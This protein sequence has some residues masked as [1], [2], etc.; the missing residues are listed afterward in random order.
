MVALANPKQTDRENSQETNAGRGREPVRLAATSRRHWKWGLLAAALVGAGGMA[1]AWAGL[2]LEDTRPVAVL[3]SDLP[4]GHVLTAA[5]VRTADVPEAEGLRMLTPQ[6]VHGQ[7]L[8]RP[9][10]AG[11]PLVT[12][13]VGDRAVWPDEGQAVAAVPVATVPHGLEAGTAVDVV[14]SGAAEGT[15]GASTGF[16]HRVVS[17]EDGFGGGQQVVEVV[18]SREQAAHVSRAAAETPA[19][20]VVVHPRDDARA[21]AQAG[22][23]R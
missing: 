20:I 2:A 11:S 7:V 19:Q 16:V 13:S 5:D 17:A 6:Q 12:G 10:L 22:G 8:T 9:T 4:A 14:V 15:T 18:L 1:G 23:A 3:A 21:F